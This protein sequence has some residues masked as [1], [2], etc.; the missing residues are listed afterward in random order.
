M[1]NKKIKVYEKVSDDAHQER[2][3]WIFTKW[4]LKLS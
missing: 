4:P 3:G 1:I 2:H